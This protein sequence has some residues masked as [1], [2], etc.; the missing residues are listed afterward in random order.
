[1]KAKLSIFIMA[2]MMAVPQFAGK[3]HAGQWGVE[4]TVGQSSIGI[5]RYEDN[6]AGGLYLGKTQNNASAKT[7]E[8]VIGGWAELRS[9]IAGGAYFAYGIDASLKS[10]QTTGVS[11]SSSYSVSPFVSIE[12][13]PVPSVLVSVWTGLVDYNV[14]EMSGASSVTTVSFAKTSL[15]F[16]YLF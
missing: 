7:D 1:M 8:T 15:G 6:Y 4:A 11:I 5:S 14:T 10:G 16:T 9:K 13:S 3:I 12:Y 2:A